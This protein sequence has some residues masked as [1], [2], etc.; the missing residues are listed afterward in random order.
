MLRPLRQQLAPQLKPWQAHDGLAERTRR[1][2]RWPIALTVELR[3][4]FVAGRRMQ[5]EMPVKRL[6]KWI[7]LAFG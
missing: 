7:G 1:C 5:G 2:R 6:R 3:C 4:A